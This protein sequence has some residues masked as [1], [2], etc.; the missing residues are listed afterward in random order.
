VFILHRSGASEVHIVSHM[1][2]KST[3]AEAQNDAKAKLD[4]EFV[5]KNNPAEGID[6][7][8][9]S[10][11]NH[12]ELIVRSDSS[13]LINRTAVQNRSCFSISPRKKQ[14]DG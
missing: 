2:R 1:C 14:R 13:T 10:W 3:F 7:Q 5:T 9:F 11:Q 6:H 4:T 8:L 12:L